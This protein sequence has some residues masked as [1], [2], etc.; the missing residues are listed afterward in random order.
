MSTVVLWQS[1]DVVA[2]W[3]KNAPHW[4]VYQAGKQVS[5]HRSEALAVRAARRRARISDIDRLAT[6]FIEL[7]RGALTEAQ[8]E[9]MRR[10]NATPEYANS[11]ASHDFVDA[12][13]VMAEAFYNVFGRHINAI[14]SRDSLIWGMAWD[15]AKARTLTATVEERV[16]HRLEAMADH[17]KNYLKQNE[18][19]TVPHTWTAQ[20]QNKKTQL[21]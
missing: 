6:E 17:L 1:G 2:E 3:D 13:M 8:W 21:P 19:A 14:S 15:I 11:C 12:N 9:E 10:R 20:A 5:E 16:N 7:L 18:S 4:R